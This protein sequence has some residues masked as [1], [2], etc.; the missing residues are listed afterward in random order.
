MLPFTATRGGSGKDYAPSKTL[1][2][3][4]EQ[5]VSI[6]GERYE[7]KIKGQA[8]SQAKVI[9]ALRTIPNEDVQQETVV[10]N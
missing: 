3:N 4:G 10:G 5:G 2:E 7:V 1:D 9:T 6:G 8:N